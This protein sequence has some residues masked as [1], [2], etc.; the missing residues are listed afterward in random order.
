MVKKEMG[1]L[2]SQLYN[3]FIDCLQ[4][5]IKSKGLSLYGE[6]KQVSFCIRIQVYV[7]KKASFKN[8]D[9]Y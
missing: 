9:F 8:F 4:M 6:R 2:A 7:S 5:C 1:K 3:T